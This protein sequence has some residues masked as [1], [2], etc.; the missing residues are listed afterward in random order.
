MSSD[1]TIIM[2]HPDERVPH[3]PFPLVHV[4]SG[5]RYVDYTIVETWSE[6]E[7]ANARA[8]TYCNECC[9]KQE[10]ESSCE[11][12]KAEVNPGLK[13]AKMPSTGKL[14]ERLRKPPTRSEE[15]MAA[16]C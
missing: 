12:E 10:K 16:R 14:F 2:Y 11:A 15:R 8:V 6:A 1:S 13:E 4:R 9:L 5:T 3:I 7:D